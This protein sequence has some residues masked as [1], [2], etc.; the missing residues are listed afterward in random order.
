MFVQV[1]TYSFVELFSIFRASAVGS[2]GRLNVSALGPHGYI[3]HLED[4]SL[5]ILLASGGTYLIQI[6]ISPF[7]HDSDVGGEL[8]VAEVEEVAGLLHLPELLGA[9][10]LVAARTAALGLRDDA[11]CVHLRGVL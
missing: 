8:L 11:L 2:I 1:K 3:F 5:K 6:L 7:S 9:S 4:R 10:D